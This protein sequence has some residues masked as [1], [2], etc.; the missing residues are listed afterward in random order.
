MDGDLRRA[1]ILKLIH[2]PR[3]Q[4]N[5]LWAKQGESNL[6]TYHLKKLED[7]GLVTKF[8]DGYGLTVEGKKLSAF[9]EGDTGGKAELPTPTVIVVPRKGNKILCQ[10]RLKEP[11]YGVWGVVSGKINFGWNPLEC[12]KRDLLEETGL[13]AHDATLRMIE[14]MKTYDNEKL[15]HHHLMYFVEVSEC[16]GELKVNT[17]KAHHEWLTPEEYKAKPKFPGNW[18]VDVVL[19]SKNFFIIEAERHMKDGKFVDAKL[20]NVQEFVSKEK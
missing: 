15:L 1:I 5:E 12:A 11:F 4:F 6:F 13:T 20:I 17:H 18:M 2:N 7:E 9:I 16:S 8:D 3:L 19:P 10:Q 14:F